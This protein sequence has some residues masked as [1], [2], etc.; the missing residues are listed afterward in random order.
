MI[1]IVSLGGRTASNHHCCR[2]R[3]VASSGAVFVHIYYTPFVRLAQTSR[4]EWKTI[5]ASNRMVI[6]CICISR[7]PDHVSRAYYYILRIASAF[8][9]DVFFFFKGWKFAN[10]KRQF[11]H[12]YSLWV[13]ST[14]RRSVKCSSTQHHTLDIAPITK[15][16]ID[17]LNI[18][19]GRRRI[20][21]K[22]GIDNYW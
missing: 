6:E 5:K 12:K 22:N 3:M 10:V 1:N 18:E 21:S 16:D 2:R 8:G 20:V 9:D 19:C 11:V 13:I 7:S 15:N 17:R 4:T 14:Q